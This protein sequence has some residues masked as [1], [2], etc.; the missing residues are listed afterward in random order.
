M[1]HTPR[2]ATAADLAP[3]ARLWH[4]GWHEAHAAIVPRSLTSMRTLESFRER[5]GR[6]GDDLRAAGPEG[7][8]LGFCAVKDDELYQLFVSQKSRGTGLAAMLLADG[9]ARLAERGVARA[10][11]LCADGNDRAALF[12]QR[13]GWKNLGLRNESVETEDG[14]F[15]FDLLRFEKE[16]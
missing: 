14:P 13:A 8:P 3:L 12:Y 10:V 11:L 4:A 2:P 1:T 5:L 9:E 7:A 6:M 16:L 15:F